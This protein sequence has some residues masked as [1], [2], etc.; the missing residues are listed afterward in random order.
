MEQK[1]YWTLRKK[2]LTGYGLALSLI[3]A[4]LIWSLINMVRLSHAAEAILKENYKSILAAENMIDSL[5]R[6][7]SAILL[8]MLNYPDEAIKQFRENENHFLLWLGR[9]KDNITIAGEDKIVENIDAG[10]S[11]YLVKFSNLQT[12]FSSDAGKTAQFYHENVLPSFK[13]VRDECIQLREINQNTMFDASSK[14]SEVSSRAFWSVFMIGSISVAVGLGFS[15]LLA[16]LFVKPV[17]QIIKAT[18]K[19]SEGDYN[20]QVKS[21]SRDEIGIMANDFNVMVK[22]LKA[23]RNLNFKKILSEKHKS[24]TIIRSIDDGLI[25]LNSELK[26]EDINPTAAKIFDKTPDEIK[27]YHLLEV[28]KDEKIYNYLKQA[29]QSENI[30]MP[31]EPDANIITVDKG[32]S[33]QHYL[34]SVTPVPADEQS[35]VSMVLLLRDI[36]RLKELDRL[37]SEFVMAA[38]HELK[39]PLTSIG[40]S[41]S[42]LKEK[43]MDKLDSKE[44]ELLN[45]ADEEVRRLKALVSDLLDISK[46][47]AGKLDIEFDSV[48]VELLFEK[49]VALLKKQ[50][51]EKTIELSYEPVTHM[52]DI[53]A[54]VNKITWVLTNLIS[55]SLRY[56]QANGF[57]KLS[58]EQ[59]GSQ[60]QISVADNGMG[61]PYEYQSRIFDKFVQV[62]TEKALGGSGLGLAICKEIVR[63]HGGTIW[64]DSHPGKG[65]TF[66]FTVPITG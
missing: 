38:S 39:T 12:M 55:N 24:E 41:I 14:A 66:T 36:T 8:L 62:K 33:Q 28:I 64:V 4:V 58:A 26:I 16:A 30:T 29:F 15:L 23:Y 51:E 63:A 22:K 3:V 44:S 2:V 50:A 17:H 47:E 46:I 56:T 43:S 54:D 32:Q 59:M 9:A 35:P 31:E 1:I 34:F 18:Q 42:L 20:V 53:K 19:I 57:I 45:A 27:G 11:E 21:K 49:A 25:V 5:E 7:D 6:Q 61:I 40:M 60:I 48:P 10:Y 52:P 37:K 65:S 13:S